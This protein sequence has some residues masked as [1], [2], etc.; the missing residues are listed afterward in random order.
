[1]D[2]MGSWMLPDTV[3]WNRQLRWEYHTML[4]IER[5]RFEVDRECTTNNKKS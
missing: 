3:G 1:M 5:K 4:S 2:K